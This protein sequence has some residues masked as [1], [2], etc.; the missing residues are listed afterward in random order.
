M[1]GQRSELPRIAI[2]ALSEAT[3]SVVYGMYDLFRSA[4]RDWGLILNGA[5][6]ASKLEPS[7]VSANAGPLVLANG[8]RI[9]PDVSLRQREHYSVVCVP[10]LA[11]APDH[12]IAGRYATEVKWLRKQYERGAIIATA[13]SGAVLAAEAGLLDG[14]D[15]TTHWAYCEP[16]RKQYPKVKVH[17]DRALVVSGEGQRLIMAG[18]GTTWLDLALYLIARLVDLDTA[19]QTARVNLIDWHSSGQ[20]P[21][22]RLARTRQESDAVIGK[23]QE[24]IAKHYE[25]T[26]PVASMVRIC[27]LPERTFKRRFQAATGSAPLAYVHMLR[28]EAAKERLET[29]DDSI[30]RIA[31]DIGYE[32]AAFFA[33]LFRRAVRLT[34]AQYRRRFAALRSHLSARTQPE[35]AA[36]R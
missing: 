15:A 10:E 5:P 18:G 28:L 33:R 35:R 22:A 23:A 7:I 27:G 4:G 24:W 11:I 25:A 29:G 31:R 26:A 30:E 1:P 13:C 8:V 9:M 3:A 32:D 21:F 17:E 20:Q 2:L 12:P 14:Q 19:M 16:L 6:G 34:P 36:R